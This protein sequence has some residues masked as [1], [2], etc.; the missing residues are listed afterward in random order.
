MSKW[1][2]ISKEGRQSFA[3]VDGANALL[4]DAPPYAGG[5]PTGELWPLSEVRFLPP[6][7]PRNFYAAGLNYA[8]H[9]AWAKDHYGKDFRVPTEAEIGYRSPSALVGSGE[10]VILPA[11]SQGSFEWEGELVAVIGRTVRNVREE[12][13]LDHVAGYTLGNDLSER[14]WQFSDRTFWRAKNSDTFK[15]MGP[16]VV[17]GIDPM[18][19]QIDVRVNG[20]TVS[21]YNTRGMVFSLAHYMA[22]MSRYVTLHP[23]D[24]IWL[25]CDGATVP[26]LKAGDTVEVSCASIGSLVNR[27]TRAT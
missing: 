3:L 18:N 11:D 26:G 17:D 2:R 25:G 1:C 6:V 23:G 9:I 8:G 22:R 16:F 13:A 7:E 15:P 10:D 14:S 5:V 20:V 19:L 21:T 4:L 24:V 12:E 27:I